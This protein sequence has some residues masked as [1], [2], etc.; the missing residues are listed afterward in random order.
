MN[1]KKVYIL[2]ASWKDS[3]PENVG[4]FDSP[5][6]M[7]A[8]LAEAVFNDHKSDKDKLKAAKAV[9]LAV[10]DFV[11]VSDF[12][13]DETDECRDGDTVYGWEA[14]EVQSLEE[15]EKEDA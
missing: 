1:G 10:Y 11:S 15:K 6:A 12:G 8:G 3:E 13:E 9:A 7:V 14:E 2:R 4:V 5:R